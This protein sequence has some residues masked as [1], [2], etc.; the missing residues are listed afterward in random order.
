MPKSIHVGDGG[1]SAD[2]GTKLAEVW[3]YEGR[4][5]PYI[6]LNAVAGKKPE[7]F[8]AEPNL[9]LTAGGPLPKVQRKTQAAGNPLTGSYRTSDGRWL[10]FSMLQP[11]RFWNEFVTA[12]GLEHLVDDERF[13]TMEDIFA[14]SEEIGNWIADA[15]A[16]RTYAEWTA[17]LKNLSGPWAR[18]GRV[19]RRPRRGVDRQRP[20]RRDH[21]LRR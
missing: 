20:D 9:A 1:R 18:A 8:G 11:T 12:I 7:E 16:T 14:H 6:G 4:I 5:Y 13:A 17:T 10:Q 2:G 21:R 15:I 3:E 19:G